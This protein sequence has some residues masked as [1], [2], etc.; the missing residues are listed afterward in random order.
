MKN[1]WRGLALV[2]LPLT[3]WSAQAADYIFPG[4][5]PGGCADQGND[6]YLCGAL[7]LK[8]DTI[9]IA[10]G[11]SALIRINGALMTDANAHINAAGSPSALTLQAVAVK[12]VVAFNDMIMRPGG[13]CRGWPILPG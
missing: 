5:L 3:A 2:L 12:L 13:G 8:G 9:T 1:G 6:H 7:T 11:H 4:A 10:P